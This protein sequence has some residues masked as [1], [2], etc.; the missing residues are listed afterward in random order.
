MILQ[1]SLN[2]RGGSGGAGVSAGGAE[3]AKRSDTLAVPYLKFNFNLRQ[4]CSSP[5]PSSSLSSRAAVN[6]RITS[7]AQLINSRSPEQ[8]QPQLSI[9][10]I[11][12]AIA[13]SICICI[14]L[15]Q[16]IKSAT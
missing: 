3:A 10:T 8:Q 6:A 1:R 13:I 12:I 11:S 9:S 14:G 15:T 4:L 2:H 5:S 16:P 7:S